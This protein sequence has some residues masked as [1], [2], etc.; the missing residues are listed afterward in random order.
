MLVIVF[1]FPLALLALV[2]GMSALEDGLD[3]LDERER[4]PPRHRG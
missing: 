2:L 3:R 1:L 4:R